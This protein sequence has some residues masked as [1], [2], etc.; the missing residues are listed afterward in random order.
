[1]FNYY[2]YQNQTDGEKVLF[3]YKGPLNNVLLAD[4]S[5][6]IRKRLK[7]YDNV[8]IGNKVFAIFM[9]LSQNVLYYSKESDQFDGKDKVGTLAIVK[10]AEHYKVM[11]GN[12]VSR[13]AVPKILKKCETINSLDREALREFK[14]QQRALGPDTEDSKGAGIGLIHVALTSDNQLEVNVKEIDENLAFYVLA[15]NIKRV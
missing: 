9:E 2:E 11:T 14:R 5:N 12:L 3:S 7:L 10:T 8:S 1:M 6:N 13:T 4:F 15:V